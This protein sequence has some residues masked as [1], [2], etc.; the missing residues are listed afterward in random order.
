MS[1]GV[2]SVSKTEPQISSYCK[3]T[4]IETIELT[5]RN[6]IS[7]GTSL[8]ISETAIEFVASKQVQGWSRFLFSSLGWPCT[9]NEV[10]LNWHI[11]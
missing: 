9:Q 3:F 6:V 1:P 5:L 4:Q 8:Y 2:C 10:Q 7:N 11:P